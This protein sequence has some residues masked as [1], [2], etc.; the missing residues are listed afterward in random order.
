[1]VATASG[2]VPVRRKRSRS[3]HR[4]WRGSAEGGKNRNGE[5]FYVYIL[6]SLTN[7]R[8]YVGHTEDMTTRL[9]R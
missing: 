3:R 8:H 2:G 5:M 6:E 4:L 1:M 9:Q 7:E